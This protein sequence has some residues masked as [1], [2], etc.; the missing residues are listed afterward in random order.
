M[1][2]ERA[3]RCTSAPQM[4]R[5]MPITT[6]KTQPLSRRASSGWEPPRNAE[7]PTAPSSVSEL[8]TST[9]G[10]II[11]SS[12]LKT[13]L[14][15][16][17]LLSFYVRHTYYAPSIVSDNCHLIDSFCHSLSLS[18]SIFTNIEP[19][20]SSRMIIY[21][22]EPIMF[23]QIKNPEFKNRLCAVTQSCFI[24]FNIGLKKEF[25]LRQLFNSKLE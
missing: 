18:L 24:R 2:R 15:W 19:H 8:P 21:L 14:I 10:E 12:H 6:G 16:V 22:R 1:F 13:K 4:C 9:V 23:V 7:H 25:Q 20:N 5:C 17:C 3:T 11:A